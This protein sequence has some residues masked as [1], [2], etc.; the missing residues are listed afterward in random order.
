MDS[1]IETDTMR[2][3]NLYKMD[4]GIRVLYVDDE[5]DLLDITKLYLERS[6]EFDIDT[7]VSAERALDDSD[8][9]SY[10]A[11]VSDYMMPG[12]DGIAFLRA[13]RERF[14]DIPFILFTGRGR[15]DVVIRALNEGVDFYLQKGGDPKAQFAELVHKIRQ[16]VRRRRAEISVKESEEMYRTILEDI[17]DVYYR[18]D[19][20]GN[21]IMLSPSGYHLLGYDPADS[22]LGGPLARKFLANP[23]DCKRLFQAI[24]GRGAVRDIEID[25]KQKDGTLVTVSANSHSF[26]GK[27]GRVA[28]IEGIF[29]DITE[30][31]RSEE[32]LKRSENLYLSLI[33]ISEP[34]RPY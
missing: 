25:L 2:E 19:R 18:A 22:I 24:N 21:L 29:R 27:D 12:M 32:E 17:Q 10:D 28:G 7:S 5:P 20:D 6:G 34:T 31:K 15:E 30:Q 26:F 13:V 1:G 3:N 23:D 33:H 9:G 4:D 11:I 8:I 14:G 16:A